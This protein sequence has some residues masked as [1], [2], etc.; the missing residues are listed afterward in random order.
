MRTLAQPVQILDAVL[1]GTAR[2]WAEQ[3]IVR[4]A[5]TIIGTSA[6]GPSLCT[7]RAANFPGWVG[8]YS[9][10]RVKYQHQCCRPLHGSRE[11]SSCTLQRLHPIG[12]SYPLD[13]PYKVH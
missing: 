9:V 12:H 6:T 3:Q 2:A 10:R 13:K 5:A 8:S 1:T 11:A 4:S 7:G